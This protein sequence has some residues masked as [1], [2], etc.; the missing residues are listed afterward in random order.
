MP[1]R[2]LLAAISGRQHPREV[3]DDACGRT[4]PL[5]HFLMMAA[6]L[7]GRAGRD[8][9]A[10]LHVNLDAFPADFIRIKELCVLA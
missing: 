2:P 3:L 1:S 9:L 5:H 4:M 6:A 8:C 7:V 10:H